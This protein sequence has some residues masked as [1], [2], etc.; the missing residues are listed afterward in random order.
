METKITIRCEICGKSFE[1]DYKDYISNAQ[2][3]AYFCSLDCYSSIIIKENNAEN[4]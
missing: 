3:L 1:I 4:K 2:P